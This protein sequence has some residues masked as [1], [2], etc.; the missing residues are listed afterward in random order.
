MADDLLQQFDNERK[1]GYRPSVLITLTCKK[2]LLVFYAKEYQQWVF[3]QTG[4]EN[5]ET[6]ETTLMRL[7]ETEVGAYVIEKL[8]SPLTMVCEKKSDFPNRVQGSKDL[9]TDSGEEV[10]MIG[11]KYYIFTAELEDE[12]IDIGKSQFSDYWWFNEKEAR[13][14]FSEMP[15]VN[16]KE[17]MLY[18][19]DNLKQ[20]GYVL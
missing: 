9:R 13:F 11:K 6:F 17:V 4:I 14:I 1:Q 7:L 5:G 16:K 2:K 8:A 15:H 12:R 20:K 10:T 18:A 3:P 19:L